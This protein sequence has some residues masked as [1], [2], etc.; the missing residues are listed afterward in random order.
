[1]TE[2]TKPKETK[3]TITKLRDL[4]KKAADEGASSLQLKELKSMLRQQSGIHPTKKRLNKK[5]RKRNRK[6][7][8]LSRKRN[9]NT[10]KGINNHKGIHY[11]TS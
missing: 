4:I 8:K 6:A 2:E 3:G 11:R 5:S 10:S 7:A 9:R 1:M